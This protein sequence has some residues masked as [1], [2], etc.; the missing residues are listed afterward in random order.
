M[1]LPV[2]LLSF[3]SAEGT[4]GVFIDMCFSS[5]LLQNEPDTSL[6]HWHEFKLRTLLSFAHQ[7][8]AG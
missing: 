4:I 8:G 7:P 5:L 6:S 1:E 3:A 2:Q